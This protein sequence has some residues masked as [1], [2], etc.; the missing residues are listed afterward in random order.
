MRRSGSRPEAGRPS[1]LR[2]L[3]IEL[4]RQLELPF[5]GGPTV[6]SDAPSPKTGPGVGAAPGP[7]PGPARPA[8]RPSKQSL[9]PT[10]DRT[11]R[12]IRFSDRTL[13]YTL[14][15]ARRKTIGFSIGVDGLTVAA[16]RGVTL[17]RIEEALREREKWVVTKLDA[18]ERH[19]AAVPQVRWEDGGTLPYLGLPL[20]LRLSAT[21]AARATRS[22]APAFDDA[23]R[24]LTLDV[25][26]DA[27]PALVRRHVEAWLRER[28]RALFSER[29]AFYETRLG[30]NHRVLRLSSARTRWGSCSADGRILLNWRLVHFPL[31]SIDYVVAH[32]LAH[33]KEMNHGPRFWATVA[34]IFPDYEAVRR[35]MKS[36][37]PELLPTL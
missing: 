11:P 35:S 9:P 18:L 3:L 12:R 23:S 27:P 37:P 5:R 17:D 6:R 30:R 25:P 1:A 29:L 33:L 13:D 32:E 10:P 4:G 22:T 7:R 8:P 24:V 26:A 2:R 36:P 16:P 34:S 28:A 19:R 31:S 21:T 15:R 20:T 14:R